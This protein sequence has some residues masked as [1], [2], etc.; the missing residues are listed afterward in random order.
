VGRLINSLGE[1]H[2][3][4]PVDREDESAGCRVVVGEG[5]FG[6]LVDVLVGGIEVDMAVGGT[7]VNVGCRM[8]A[9]GEG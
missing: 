1:I 7:D 9:V 8:A 4:L 2:M 6:T 3:P 5:C